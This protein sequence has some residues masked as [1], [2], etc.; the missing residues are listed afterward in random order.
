MQAADAISAARPGTRK[1]SLEQY[2]KRLEELEGVVNHFPNIEK[3]FAIQAGREARVVV[4]PESVDDM[5]ASVLAKDIAKRIEDE[6][7]S[8]F[9]NTKCVQRIWGSRILKNGRQRPT[10]PFA[11]T[12][13]SNHAASLSRKPL[14]FL[15]PPGHGFR[16]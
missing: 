5:E 3:A 7:D 9:K 6:L 10:L 13:S 8:C 2:V 11:L 14:R 16:I 12:I 15:G 1:E 4:K